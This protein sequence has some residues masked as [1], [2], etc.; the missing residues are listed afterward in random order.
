MW[1]SKKLMLIY[2]GS[3]AI[4]LD[5]LKMVLK[6]KECVVHANKKNIE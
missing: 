2:L 4:V 6:F 1:Y 3:Y 5:A